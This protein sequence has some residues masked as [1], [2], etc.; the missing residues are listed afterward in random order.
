VN[1]RLPL[2]NAAKPIV[3]VETSSSLLVGETMNL[4]R[5]PDAVN[6]P[7]RFD[8]REVETEHGEASEALADE[9]A[10]NR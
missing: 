2:A 9:R 6:P 8:E 4:V 3:Q 1:R 7:V 5:E 10:S